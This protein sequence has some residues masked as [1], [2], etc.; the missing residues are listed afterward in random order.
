MNLK[1]WLLPVLGA[2]LGLVSLF[3]DPKK[4]S[5]AKTLMITLMVVSGIVTIRENWA[6]A[7]KGRAS[8]EKAEARL[9]KLIETSGRTDQ[10]T[11]QILTTIKSWGISPEV[12]KADTARTASLKKVQVETGPRPNVVYFPKQVDG[13]LVVKALE[14]AHFTVDR[15]ASGQKNERATNMIWV[16]AD[17]AVEDAKFVALTLVR[18]GVH[19]KAIRKFASSGGAKAKVVEVGS[20]PNLID[21]PAMTVDAIQAVTQITRDL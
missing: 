2:G 16:G 14:E 15:R 1:D 19:V 21:A 7:A 13:D 18:A 11:G 8:V 6:D 20:D 12:F 9:D 10:T 17:V 4:S 5:G 3:L